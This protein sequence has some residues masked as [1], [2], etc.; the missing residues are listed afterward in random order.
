MLGTSAALLT[1]WLTTLMPGRS[2]ALAAGT[3][4]L[5]V[6]AVAVVLTFWLPEPPAEEDA[7]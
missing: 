5:G 3:V 7:E 1:T 4:A 6:M 2:T